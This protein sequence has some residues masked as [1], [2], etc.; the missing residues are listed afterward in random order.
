MDEI[1]FLQCFKFSTC[2]W[3]LSEY[4]RRLRILSPNVTAQILPVFERWRFLWFFQKKLSKTWT[5]FF[6]FK[7]SNSQPCSWGLSEYSQWLRTLPPIMTAVNIVFFEIR[8]FLWLFQKKIRKLGRNF[9][10][11]K[12]S[13]SQPCS[14]GYQSALRGCEPCLQLWLLKCL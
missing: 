1:F 2:S 12:I 8:R 5:K 6:F 10:F 7:I 13:N 11:F 9:F 3:G 4:S 14:L